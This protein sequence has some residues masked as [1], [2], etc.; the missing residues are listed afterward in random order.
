MV[1][2]VPG[3]WEK[4]RAPHGSPKWPVLLAGGGCL[5]VAAKS[6]RIHIK[7]GKS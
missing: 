5:R 2:D 1:A 7:F 6:L 3:F 4:S